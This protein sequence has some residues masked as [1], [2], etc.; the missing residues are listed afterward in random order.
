VTAIESVGLADFKRVV[1]WY[2]K[3]V[4]INKDGKRRRRSKPV[5]VNER[6]FTD[7]F[8]IED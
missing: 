2:L 4:A 1:T 5:M 8:V 6:D 7:L 3:A